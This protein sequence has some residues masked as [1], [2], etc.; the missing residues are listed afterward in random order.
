MQPSEDEILAALAHYRAA[1]LEHNRIALTHFVHHADTEQPPAGSRLTASKIAEIRRKYMYNLLCVSRPENLDP[2]MQIEAPAD[3]MT[4][5]DAMVRAFG[6]DGVF[7]SPNTEHR[8]ELCATYK[9]CTEA[10]LCR[11][12]ADVEFPADFEFL[13]NQVDSLQG[14]GWPQ[15][16]EHG[17]QIRFW[18]GLDESEGDVIGPD[19]DLGGQTGLDDDDW[20]VVA[21]WECGGGPETRCFVVYCRQEQTGKEW[22]WRYV[23]DMG[24]YGV[25]VFDNLVELLQWYETLHVP[26]LDYYL[27]FSGCGIFGG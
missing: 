6:L 20:E 13:M 26:D 24:Q 1:V 19:D 4:K 18:Y 21:G 8:R 3:V 27:N 15:Y 7:A 14:H 11:I 25:E 16:H 22:R 9:R 2:S 23:A 12:G 5:W 17:Q 10:E